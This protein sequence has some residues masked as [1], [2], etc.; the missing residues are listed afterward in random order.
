MKYY[1]EIDKDTKNVIKNYILQTKNYSFKKAELI[2]IEINKMIKQLEENPR[3]YRSTINNSYRK[4]ILTKIGYICYFK[5]YDDE[6][7]V[8]IYKFVSFKENK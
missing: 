8:N 2:Q 6:H 4:A 5:I 3:I 1:I 7:L